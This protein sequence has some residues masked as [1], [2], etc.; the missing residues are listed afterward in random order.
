MARRNFHLVLAYDGTDFKGWQRLGVP[1]RD[2]GDRNAGDN[3]GDNRRDDYGD[4]PRRSGRTVQGELERVLSD[5][6]GVPMEVVGAGRTDAGVHAE[7]QSSSFHAFT[8][9]GCAELKAGLNARLPPDLACLS[10]A[11]VD[12]RFHARLHARSKVYRYRILAS[13]EPDPFLGRYSL[14]I[15]DRPD[16]EAMRAAGRRLVG[17]RDFRALS[18]A[19]G[20]DTVRRLDEA[21]VESTR[22][23][24]GELIDLVFVGPGFLYNQVRIMASLLLEAGRG[25]L[26]PRR[27][28]SILIGRDRSAAPGALAARGLCLVEVG[29]DRGGGDSNSGI[30]KD[31][32]R[33]GSYPAGRG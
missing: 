5:L 24:G 31:E 32:G 7:G 2:A 28:D 8:D 11:E 15:G 4:R 33:G 10:C 29:Y 27:I 16:L 19:K 30:S 18:N 20:E 12:S 3:N 26:D 17:E 9:L 1:A 25:A 6:L 14:R 23:L 22:H 21:R 13:E